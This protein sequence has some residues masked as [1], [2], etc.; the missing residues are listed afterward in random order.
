MDQSNARVADARS[1]RSASASPPPVPLADPPVPPNTSAASRHCRR[2]RGAT[3]GHLLRMGV[4]P[5]FAPYGGSR[6]RVGGQAPRVKETRA[7]A[8]GSARGRAE[9]KKK[10]LGHRGL[11]DRITAGGPPPRG[12]ATRPC[13]RPQRHHRITC[14]PHL[15]PAP[16]CRRFMPTP[17]SQPRPRFH[18]GAFPPAAAAVAV[19]IGPAAP[20]APHTFA[21]ESR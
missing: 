5:T 17:A 19:I 7:V 13:D 12:T 16:P 21:A 14:P 2:R 3:P 4:V 9:T 15:T 1:T 10:R 18:A 8:D 20:A 11:S 6:R